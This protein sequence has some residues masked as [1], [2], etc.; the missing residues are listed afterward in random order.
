MYNMRTQDFRQG[1]AKRV[2]ASINP[3]TGKVMKEFEPHSDQ[4]VE[5]RLAARGRGL[6]GGP[7]R[8]AAERA[9]LM[10]RAGLILESEKGD[11]A[12][13]MTLEMGKPLRAAVQEVEKCA[14]ACHYYA[15]NAARFLADEAASSSATRSF[16]RYRAAGAG[17]GGDAVE[18]PLLAGVPV[19]RAGPDGRQR[20]P[21]QARVECA[22]MR[23]GNRGPLPP[24]RFC[25]R[26]FPGAVGGLGSGGAA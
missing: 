16:V 14:L 23:A 22:A 13:L 24:G 17:A 6:H 2:M 19:C 25:G 8:A 20:G 5:R 18:L 12:R 26:S 7:A 11:L 10:R 15:R 21:A 3:A 9:P 1:T 4:E